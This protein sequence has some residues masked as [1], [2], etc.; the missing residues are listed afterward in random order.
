MP[1]QILGQATQYVSYTSAVTAGTDFSIAVPADEAWIIIALNADFTADAN[2][3][4]RFVGFY[5]LNITPRRLF[6]TELPTKIV[7]NDV[8]LLE[9]GASMPVI[10]NSTAKFQT[11]GFPAGIIVPG[12]GSV[13]SITTNIQAGDQYTDIVIIAQRFISASS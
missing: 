9:A 4:D 1:Q 8:W 11:T 2:V 6:R 7:A 10:T 3:I 12:G 13:N 5:F